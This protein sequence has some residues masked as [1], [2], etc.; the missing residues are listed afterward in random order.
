[1]AMY[2][3]KFPKHHIQVFSIQEVTNKTKLKSKPTEQQYKYNFQNMNKK[4]KIKNAQDLS[5]S[6]KKVYGLCA[7]A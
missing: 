4:I 6:M 2:Q 3:K 7:H 5:L 1:M